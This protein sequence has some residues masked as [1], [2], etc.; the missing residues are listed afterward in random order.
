MLTST[1]ISIEIS[2]KFYYGYFKRNLTCHY[3]EGEQSNN[4]ENA[5][6]YLNGSDI[7]LSLTA[8]EYVEGNGMFI[9]TITQ[10]LEGYYTCGNSSITSTNTLEL[11]GEWLFTN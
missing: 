1:G 11:V 2:V 10:E 8:D 6:F 5:V 3:N 9:F 4:V 7:R